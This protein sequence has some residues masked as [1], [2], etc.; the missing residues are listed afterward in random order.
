MLY[1]LIPVA[2]FLMTV[3]NPS[4]AAGLKLE[5]LKHHLKERKSSWTAA[6][7]GIAESL[8]VQQ[9]SSP[10]GLTLPDE[11]FE[12]ETDQSFTRQGLPSQLDWRNKD[13]VNWLT[14]IRNQGYCGSCVAFAALGALESRLSIAAKTPALSPDLSEQYLFKNIGSCD[15]GSVPFLATQSLIS[16]GT[17][18]ESCSPYTLGRA[19]DE[20]SGS[21]CKTIKSRLFKISGAKNIPGPSLKEALQ[22]GPVSTTMK[23]FEDFMYYKSGIYRH[24]KGGSVGGH[25][26]TIVGYDDEQGVWIARNSWGQGWGE[27][28][29]FRIPY[30]ND[31]RLGYSGVA[32][33]VNTPNQS[34]GISSPR[35]LEPYSGFFRINAK[36][37]FKESFESIKFTLRKTPSMAVV[38]EG[39]LDLSRFS[40]EINS[41][42]LEDG[43]YEVEL[44]P[45]P[46]DNR[47][48]SSVFSTFTIVNT[49][50]N[51]VLSLVPEF[52]IKKPVSGRVY[53]RIHAKQD[54]V[55]LTHVRIFYKMVEG[56]EEI[57]VD[58]ENPGDKVKVG[59]KTNSLTNGK[60][61]IYAIGYIGTKQQFKSA[62][63]MVTV[64]N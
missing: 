56:S 60:Y 18:D 49:P 59:W 63:V 42:D 13:G 34:V 52:D 64:E 15:M 16:D 2:L 45:E 31:S 14:D 39:S 7:S 51:L 17:P 24:E 54:S 48:T 35:Y 53:F 20:Y 50:Q 3:S 57:S 8:G 11:D 19:G 12:I 58:A 43:V 22:F 25:A 37:Y 44:Q 1:S 30:E 38:K 46:S 21:D 40:A 55:P 32:F 62:P 61:E 4:R 23:V 36:T 9:R 10:F 6:D 33:S 41:L 27:S 29:Y 28:G 47:P 26:V 5:S